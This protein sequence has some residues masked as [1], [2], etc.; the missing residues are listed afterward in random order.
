M[1]LPI[2]AHRSFISEAA[3]RNKNLW[4]N[5]IILLL[6]LECTDLYCSLT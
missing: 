4:R 2:D 5:N 6:A 3:G 1:K